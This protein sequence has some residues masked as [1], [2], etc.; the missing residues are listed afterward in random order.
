MNINKERKLQKLYAKKH[1]K[2]EIITI[3]IKKQNSKNYMKK[4]IE[5]ENNYSIFEMM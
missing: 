4:K 1:L 3:L 2:G 5:G